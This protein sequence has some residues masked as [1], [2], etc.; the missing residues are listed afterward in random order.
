MVN[1]KD[2]YEKGCPC[3]PKIQQ[4]KELSANSSSMWTQRQDKFGQ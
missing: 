2:D 3:Q 4:L 1:C